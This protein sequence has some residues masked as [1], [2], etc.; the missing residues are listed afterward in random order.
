MSPPTLSLF[1]EAN[2]FPVATLTSIC[3]ARSTMDIEI[4]CCEIGDKCTLLTA[5]RKTVK[6]KRALCITRTRIQQEAVYGIRYAPNSPIYYVYLSN[7][8]VYNYDSKAT[9]P[10]HYLATDIA[11]NITYLQFKDD[12]PLD[13]GPQKQWL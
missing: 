4:V 1:R 2:D 12:I 7:R 5:Q 10:L 8:H 3:I 9:S 6:F 11:T 13:K